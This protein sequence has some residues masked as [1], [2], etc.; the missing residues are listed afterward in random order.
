MPQSG[1]NGVSE[2]LSQCFLRLFSC[3]ESSPLTE[4]LLWWPINS[5]RLLWVW[6]DQFLRN[7]D[8]AVCLG[9]RV[10]AAPHGRR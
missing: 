3:G 8:D 6:T 1:I 4:G 9:A 7:M 2:P 5:L 10:F